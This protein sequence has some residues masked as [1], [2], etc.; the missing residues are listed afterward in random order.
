MSSSKNEIGKRVEVLRKRKGLS[1]QVLATSLNVSREVVAKWENGTRD[2]KTEHTI[3]LAKHFN[4]TTDYLLGL[5]TVETQDTEIR[6]TCEHI[7]LSEDAIAVLVST[8]DY[9]KKH[10]TVDFL[11]RIIKA[12]AEERPCEGRYIARNYLWTLIS[13][14]VDFIAGY[15]LPDM[16]QPGS[17]YESDME[18]RVPGAYHQIKQMLLKFIESLVGEARQSERLQ[19]YEWKDGVRVP[20]LSWWERQDRE[21]G[22]A[23]ANNPQKR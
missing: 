21:D 13:G 10:C 14:H 4:V 17:R 2:L 8:K 20:L 11:E 1:Q 5:T 9:R 23:N 7:G 3:S 12:I 6:A 22:E 15:E 16:N 18:Y 19:R